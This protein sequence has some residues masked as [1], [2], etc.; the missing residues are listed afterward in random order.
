MKEERGD[1][2]GFGMPLRAILPRSLLPAPANLALGSCLLA[3][4]I[5]KKNMSAQ[6]KRWGSVTT[7]C[8]W[9]LDYV[10]AAFVSHMLG[11]PVI[12]HILR[13]I[14]SILWKEI[15]PQAL[16]E[17]PGCACLKEVDLSSFLHY[18][19]RSPGGPK[20]KWQ[21]YPAADYVSWIQICY[22]LD[23]RI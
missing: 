9:C 11:T 12:E 15:P 23:F 16:S 22:D 2:H 4:T 13:K 6:W 21:A 17:R 5:Q 18:Q 8:F 10:W 3:A 14:L 7:A 1:Q 19:D 20:S